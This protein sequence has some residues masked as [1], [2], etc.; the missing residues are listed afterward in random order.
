MKTSNNTNRTTTSNSNLVTLGD[1]TYCERQ[2]KAKTIFHTK[3]EAES[4]ARFE[5]STRSQDRQL[6]PYYCKSCGG[7]HLGA[8]R[9]YNDSGLLG[10]S[11]ILSS[12]ATESTQW[13][14]YNC[15][16]RQTGHG[17]AAEDAN[18]LAD[19]YHGHK[20]VKT[21]YDNTSDG[22]DRIVDGVKVQTKYCQSARAT[23]NSAFDKATGKYR[24]PDQQ[25]EVPK[26]QYDEA[27]KMMEEKIRD[28]KVE[29][30]SDPSQAKNLVRKGH[31]TY[32]QAVKIAKA[33]NWES[34]KF[35]IRNQAGASVTAGAISAVTTFVSAKSQG[36]TNGEALKASGIQAGKTATK[37]MIA[38]V[39]TQQFLRTSAGRA[40][41]AVLQKSANKVIDAAMRSGVGRKVIEKTA[42]G[43]GKRALTGAAARNLLSR[44][45]STNV[46]TATAAFTVS[47]IPDTVRLCSG[48]IS[49]KEFGKRTACN[50]AGAV[51]G[52]G[53]AWAG[54]AIGSC[55][56]PGIGTAIGGFIG[57]VVGGVSAS[58]GV[59]KLFVRKKS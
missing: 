35:D 54:A 9:H 57:G 8:R 17:Y 6:A 21:G 25:L 31:Y 56:C 24:Y 29:G 43:V 45:A 58:A 22:P 42:E 12:K 52:T 4:K 38:G 1:V 18:A 14:Q 51:G 50:G 23:V 47:V 39:A 37:T 16:E 53:G 49:G 27:V 44:T 2:N 10:T 13:R 19:R 3:E 28:G 30:V 55:I 7:W 33:G 20:V 40:T 36:A 59:S 26:D 5:N 34:I 48:K 15:G 46:I 32:D 11:A 41:T